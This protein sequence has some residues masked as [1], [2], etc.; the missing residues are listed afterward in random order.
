MGI[1]RLSTEHDGGDFDY[2]DDGA[3]GED[4]VNDTD[5]SNCPE[6]PVDKLTEADW[7]RAWQ[8]AR[9]RTSKF[10]KDMFAWGLLRDIQATA[11]LPVQ[12]PT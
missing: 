12:V 4:T 1:R 3:F 10:V 5:R 6:K 7:K 9:T 11:Q 2:A 8:F